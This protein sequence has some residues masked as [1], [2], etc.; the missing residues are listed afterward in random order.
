MINKKLI[1]T[2]SM[3]SGT[4][5]V[6]SILNSQ[7]NLFCIERNPWKIPKKA[8]Y[9][10]DFACNVNSLDAN[11]LY[12]GIE[13]PNFISKA[14][15]GDSLLD[16]YIDYL[17]N[18]YKV[19]NVGF[20]ITMMTTN[21]MLSRINEGYKIIIVRRDPE[22]IL[23]SWVTRI[24]PDINHAAS[25]LYLWLKEIN[26]YSP[27]LP[28]NSYIV[29]DYED[30]IKDQ[31]KI[32]EDLSKFLKINLEIPTLR[33]HSFNKNR[34]TFKSNTSFN[35]PEKKDLI[36]NNLPIKYDDELFKKVANLIINKKFKISFQNFLIYNLK[37]LLKIDYL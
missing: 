26:F 28:L 22:Q 20:K 14:K 7:K 2:G 31:E 16:I 13:P 32:L 30:L 4:T 29:V 33:Y 21:E 8:K 27:N 9:Y 15:V 17:K 5:Y 37:K 3:R 24:N 23:K 36:V 1:V 35:Y 11:F 10:E 18:I 25:K 19:E 6:A 12:L 34:S